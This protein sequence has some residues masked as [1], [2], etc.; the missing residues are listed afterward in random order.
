MRNRT[1]C[2]LAVAAC[3]TA[4]EPTPPPPPPAVAAGTQADLARE[5]GDA[6]A[7]GTWIELR[8]RWQGQAVRWTVT[9]HRALCATAARCN[10]AAFPIQRPAQHGWLPE[11]AF[12]PGAYAALDAACAAADPCEV[13]IEGTL[14]TLVAGD[15]VPTRVQIAD[16]RIA[17]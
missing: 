1:L 11:L 2:L 6:A 5:L 7:R 14:A 4:D 3:S 13:T 15:D 10:V 8:R 9:R 12:A 16:A 17:R